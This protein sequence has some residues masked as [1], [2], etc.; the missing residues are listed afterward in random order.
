MGNSPGGRALDRACGRRRRGRGGRAAASRLPVRASCSRSSRSD[1][2]EAGGG[3]APD[4]ASGR[5]G[6]RA[7]CSSRPSRPSRPS[8][9]SGSCGSMRSSASTSKRGDRGRL[10]PVAIGR[11][12]VPRRVVRRGLLDHVLVRGD[13]VVEPRPDLEVVPPELPALLGIVDPLL[14]PAPLLLLRDVEEHLDDRRA[15]VDEHPLPLDDVPR[16]CASRPPPAR[17]RASAPRRRPRSASG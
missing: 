7:C 13:V 17:A 12:D 3:L 15:L 6:R 14:Q 1:R 4:R 2:G 5:R 8:S 11:H 10:D 9:G 16:A